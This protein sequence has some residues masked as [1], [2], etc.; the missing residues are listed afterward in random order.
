MDDK[1]ELISRL[2]KYS[3]EDIVFTDHALLR[4]KMRQIDIENVKRN[5]L[6]PDGFV[7][8]RKE[9]GCGHGEAKFD[10]YLSLSKGLAHRYVIVLNKK[11]VVITV[12]KL[13]KKWQARVERYA[14]VHR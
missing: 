10:C 3:A 4:A 7:F 11:V 2:K 5:L 1:L 9:S 12:I 6:K 14:K 8:A 13:R